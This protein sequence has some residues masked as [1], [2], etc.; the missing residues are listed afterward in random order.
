MSDIGSTFVAME[1]VTKRD[2]N[3]R[4]AAVLALVDADQEVVVTEH[5]QPKWRISTHRNLT[6]GLER[7]GT[8]YTPPQSEPI[9][10]PDDSIG[11]PLSSA[12][13]DSLLDEVKGE[14]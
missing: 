6:T 12:E 11:P 4:T 8:A 1:T 14:I 5:G 7:L 10:W 9:A 3:Q 2:L 13:V